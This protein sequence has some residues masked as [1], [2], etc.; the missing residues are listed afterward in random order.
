MLLIPRGCAHGFQ[1]LR[2]DTVLN[3]KVDQY[4]T[5]NADSGVRYDDPLINIDFPIK[6]NIVISDKDKSHKDWVY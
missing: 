6:E 5:P 4:F 1:S 2:D 3:Y